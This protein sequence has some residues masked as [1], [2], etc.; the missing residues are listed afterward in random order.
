[1][2]TE[3]LPHGCGAGM[4]SVRARWSIRDLCWQQNIS[5]TIWIRTAKF[6]GYLLVVN[7]VVK[8]GSDHEWSLQKSIWKLIYRNEI[9]RCQ[10]SHSSEIPRS[11]LNCTEH[12]NC[13]GSGINLGSHPV[14]LD[15]GSWWQQ[16]QSCWMISLWVNKPQA[17]LLLMD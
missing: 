11:F 8:L 5:P 4:L 10:T 13:L 17:I 14:D 15:Q 16:L 9:W 6:I 12:R 1:M 7:T 2:F 3:H